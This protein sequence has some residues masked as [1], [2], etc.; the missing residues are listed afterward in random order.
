[1]RF[2]GLRRCYTGPSVSLEKS[3]IVIV[4]FAKR[5]RLG[6]PR[7]RHSMH[8][9]LRASFATLLYSILFFTAFAPRSECTGMRVFIDICTYICISHIYIY[10][11]IGCNS[12]R[13]FFIS[14]WVIHIDLF[15]FWL[16]FVRENRKLNRGQTDD[17]GHRADSF[18]GSCELCKRCSI[19]DLQ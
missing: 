10:I 17:R 16:C 3:L 19:I 8:G 2:S 11:G 9:S 15:A 13:Y 14:G 4:F 18:N 6:T 7:K 5:K 1:M 12:W